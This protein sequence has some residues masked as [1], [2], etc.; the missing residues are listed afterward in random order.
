MFLADFTP[1]QPD[2]GLLLWSMIGLL[3]PII[4]IIAIVD[5]YRND[6]KSQKTKTLW[7]VAIMIFWFIAP[8]LYFFNRKALFLKREV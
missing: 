8:I 3:L 2:F 4:S 5:I 1:I 7:I 6:F